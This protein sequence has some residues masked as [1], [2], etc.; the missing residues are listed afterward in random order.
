MP[1]RVLDHVLNCEKNSLN[2]SPENRLLTSACEVIHLYMNQNFFK[3]LVKLIGDRFKDIS[4][5]PII[6]CIVI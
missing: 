1:S 2:D 3:I 5:L 6:I 4:F